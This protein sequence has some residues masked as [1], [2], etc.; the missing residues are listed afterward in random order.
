M[1]HYATLGV[2]KSATPD[3]IKKAYRKLASQHH[4]DKGGDKAKFQ[5]IQSAYDV[6]SDPQKKAQYDNPPQQMHGFPGDFQWNVHGM[7]LNNI[8]NNMFGQN[9]NMNMGGRKQVY[10]TQI[11][12]SLL[13]AFNGTNKMLELNLMSG[14][15][16][17]DVQV[18]KGVN[19]G[20]QLRFDNVIEQ[21]VLI[22]TFNILP[23][24]RFDRKGNDLYCNHSID[25]LDLIAGTSFLFK[26]IN[27]KELNVTI[28]PGTQPY[29]NVRLSGYGMPIINTG[30]FGDQ[31]ILLKPYIPDKIDSD[32]I[33][34]ILR[35]RS[36]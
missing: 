18:P 11:D 31:Y 12:I 7:D 29:V 14:K 27:G 23:D 15:K 19:Q 26:T 10:R 9:H 16:I 34:S 6:L 30:A 25:V 13:D 5:E 17:I 8:F 4:P 35:S 2:S 24:L 3:E 22:A 32:I 21:G 33:D 20:D 28:K 1:D 36:K